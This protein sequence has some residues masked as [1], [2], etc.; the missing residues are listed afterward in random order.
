MTRIITENIKWKERQNMTNVS[1]FEDLRKGTEKRKNIGYL[2]K[3]VDACE[4]LFDIVSQNMEEFPG[5][6]YNDMYMLA[7]TLTRLKWSAVELIG[8]E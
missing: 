7:E 6:S 2:F 4:E 1:N 3:T 8:K 5:L